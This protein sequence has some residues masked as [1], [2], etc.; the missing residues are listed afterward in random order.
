MSQIQRVLIPTDFSP[1]SALAFE[2]GLDL[3]RRNRAAVHLLHVIDDST[4]TTAYPDGFFVEL[5]GLRV[6]LIGEA[7]RQLGELVK[8]AEAA[9]ITP[10]FEVLI[11]RP[12]G[13]IAEA[14][15]ARDSDLIVMGTHGRS[16][17]AHLMLGSVAE[18]VIRLA[19]CAVL[20]V[21]ETARKAAAASVPKAA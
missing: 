6:M 7:S 2:Y 9:G 10:T 11:G 13:A 3:A 21:R 17:L 14:A 15:A 12:A 18:R 1:A 4:L 16:G 5:P 8:Q 19:P 20:T